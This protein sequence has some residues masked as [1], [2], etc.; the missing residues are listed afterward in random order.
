EHEKQ[1]EETVSSFKL[2][3]NRKAGI[4]EDNAALPKLRAFTRGKITPAQDGLPSALGHGPGSASNRESE[5]SKRRSRFL[6]SDI[7][8]F[9]SDDPRPRSGEISGNN[10]KKDDGSYVNEDYLSRPRS[11]TAPPS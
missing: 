9:Y 1:L 10:L 5:A 2:F 4:A 8:P 7:G 11:T 6:E 3:R